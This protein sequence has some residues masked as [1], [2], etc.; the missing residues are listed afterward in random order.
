MMNIANWLTMARIFLILPIVVLLYMPSAITCWIA[1]ALFGIASFTDYLDGAV[2]RHAKLVSNFGKFLDPLADKLLI[3]SILVMLTSL[4][5]IPAWIVIIILARELSVT[6]LRSIAATE[7]IVIAADKFGKLKTVV[8]IIAL[9]PL[10]IHEPFYGI[11]LH[12]IGMFFLY[13]ALILTIFSGIH[14]FYGYI[15]GLKTRNTGS[16]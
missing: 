7:G 11:P 3:C 4:G 14:Y 16:I 5:W 6:G 8:Q 1:A 12:I 2:A 13:I 15:S 10:I 9:I